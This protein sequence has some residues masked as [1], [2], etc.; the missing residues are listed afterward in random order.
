MIL[1]ETL[2]LDY[3]ISLLV[4]KAL[5][6]ATTILK[7]S[8]LLGVTDRTVYNYISDYGIVYDK[9]KSLYI[10]S[11]EELLLHCEVLNMDYHTSR[12][13]L[14]ALN[15]HKKL[16][17]AANALQLPESTFLRLRKERNVAYNDLTGL[18]YIQ[19]NKKALK[20]I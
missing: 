9:V 18:W 6:K 14:K 16:K 4:L 2:N 7:A 11:K 12:L 8:I 10:I 13:L 19:S 1:E 17:D 5:N 3:H 20:G 15:T